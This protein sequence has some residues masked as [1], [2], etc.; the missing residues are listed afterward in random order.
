MK[1]SLVTILFSTMIMANA[2]AQNVGDIP[3][4]PTSCKSGYTLINPMTN[5]GI[6]SGTGPAAPG[7]PTGYSKCYNKLGHT[8]PIIMGIVGTEKCCLKNSFYTTGIAN[9]QIKP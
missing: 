6:L 3:P 2:I 1:L 7:F 4:P 9:G 8:Y 5:Q